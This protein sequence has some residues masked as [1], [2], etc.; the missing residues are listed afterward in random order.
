MERLFSKTLRN[1]CRR[2]KKPLIAKPVEMRD[3]W[4]KRQGGLEMDSGAFKTWLQFT[5]LLNKRQRARAL[6]E[7]S[8]NEDADLGKKTAAVAPV[9]GFSSRP[10]QSKIASLS[11][12]RCGGDDIRRW[13][14]ANGKPRRRCMTCGKTFNPLTGTPLAGLHYPDRWSDQIKAMINGETLAQTAE[15][16]GVNYSTAFR[17]RRRFLAALNHGDP[18]ILKGIAAVDKKSILDSFES[19]R[20]AKGKRSGLSR[21]AGV[22]DQ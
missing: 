9:G 21:G 16:C 5:R 20:S 3:E 2:S 1:I 17:W 11:C 10:K 6:L 4:V 15:R 12:P 13:G 7:L 19:K 8:A 18:A 14:R 22:G